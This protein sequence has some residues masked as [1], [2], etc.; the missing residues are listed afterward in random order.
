M[1]LLFDANLAPSLVV[2]LSAV[3]PKSTHV[4]MHGDIASDDMAIWE[5]A[6]HEHYLIATKDTDFLELSLLN[7]APPKVVLLRLGN[8]STSEVEVVLRT[9]AAEVA[10]FSNDPQEAVLVV[11]R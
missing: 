4:F 1:K 11:N 3:Y 10:R 6:K 9:Y 8:V 2:R 5:L 7:G